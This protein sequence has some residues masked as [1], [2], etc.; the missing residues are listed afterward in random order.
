[1][2]KNAT[3]QLKNKDLESSHE[4]VVA[5]GSL[6]TGQS[7]QLDVPR[8]TRPAPLVLVRNY[9]TYVGSGNSG[10]R[11]PEILATSWS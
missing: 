7:S 9:T 11:F 5:L 8:F 2:A 4:Y 3:K 10:H 6:P 1:M